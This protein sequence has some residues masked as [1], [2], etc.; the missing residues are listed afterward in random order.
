MLLV[1]LPLDNHKSSTT[2]FLHVVVV[3]EVEVVVVVVVAEVDVV[4]CL[5]FS[6]LYL[7]YWLK[8]GLAGLLN[9]LCQSPAAKFKQ[10]EKRRRR[11]KKKGE[12]LS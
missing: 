5:D 11:R 2:S 7:F 8:A 9:D 6:N 3:E 4:T 10:R 1:L 12:Q